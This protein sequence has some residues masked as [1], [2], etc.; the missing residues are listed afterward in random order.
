MQV[1]RQV[2]DHLKAQG[3]VKRKQVGSGFVKTLK[4]IRTYQDMWV[5]G[6]LWGQELSRKLQQCWEG[7]VWKGGGLR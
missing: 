2:H 5:H 6:Y 7:M 1:V 3:L 4:A